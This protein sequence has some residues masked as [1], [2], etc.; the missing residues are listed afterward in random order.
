MG[1][2]PHDAPRA[3]ITDANPAGLDGFSFVEFAH[4]EPGKLHELFRLMGFTAVARHRTRRVTLYRQGDV[5]YL[6][7][8][9]PGSHAMWRTAPAR[10]AWAG[11]WRM[12]STPSRAPWRWAPSRP[13]TG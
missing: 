1:P 9:E 3:A 6:L 11:A 10:R 13:R 4:P 7:N 5:D 8:E 12:R 2:F